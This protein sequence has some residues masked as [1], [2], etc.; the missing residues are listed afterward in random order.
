M[1][2]EAFPPLFY[3][4]S[5]I[6]RLLLDTTLNIPIMEMFEDVNRILFC[7]NYQTKLLVTTC[8]YPSSFF[9]FLL[10]FFFKWR[11]VL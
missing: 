2:V 4:L 10:F 8:I 11:R 3:I 5:F 9:G 6:R 7:R 1:R